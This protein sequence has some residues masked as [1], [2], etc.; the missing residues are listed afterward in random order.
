VVIK[1]VQPFVPPLAV[2]AQ[3]QRRGA[4]SRL[5][6][7]TA[8]AAAAARPAAR[9]LPRPQ[10]RRGGDACVRSETGAGRG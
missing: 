6:A 1:V 10:L 2:Q 3:K 7:R 5:Q 8:A 9:A 4:A